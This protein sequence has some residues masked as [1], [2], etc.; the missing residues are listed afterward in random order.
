VPEIG[1]SRNCF[2]KENPVDHVHESVD[3]AGVAGP[4]FHRGL[5]GGRRHGLAGARPSGRCGPRRLVAR[6]A[7]GR[8][9]CGMTRGPLTRARTMVR[10]WRTGSGASATSG[11]GVS[12]IEEGRRRGEGVRC[13]TGVWVPFYRVG[14]EAGAAEN[15]GRWW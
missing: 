3:H 1:I 8:A 4:R 15:S 6:V 5:H 14:R 13:S 12:M 2:A 9:R 10:R 11:H 7:T